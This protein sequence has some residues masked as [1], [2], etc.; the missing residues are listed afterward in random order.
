MHAHRWPGATTKIDSDGTEGDC[1]PGPRTV[2]VRIYHQRSYWLRAGLTATGSQHGRQ[3]GGGLGEFRAS[4]REGTGDLCLLRPMQPLITQQDSQCI[5][6]VPHD[7][8]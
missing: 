8:P 5:S 4:G 1:P 3:H 6:T 2:P 7:V